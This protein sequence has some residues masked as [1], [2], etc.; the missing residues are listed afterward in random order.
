M[1]R[2]LARLWRS[3]GA[4]ALAAL[5]AAAGCT[6]EQSTPQGYFPEIPVP[7]Q[8]TLDGDQTAPGFD[9]DGLFLAFQSS[10]PPAGVRTAY[11]AQLRSAGFLPGPDREGWRAY[12]RADQVLWVSVADV[13]PPTLL[14]VRVAS[15][16]D[17]ASPSTLRSAAPG[18][19][20][21]AGPDGPGNTQGAT[22]PLPLPA[23]PTVT[24][25]PATPEPAVRR[26][27][28]PFWVPPGQGGSNPGG[29]PGN[30]HGGNGDGGGNGNGNGAGQ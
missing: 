26:G 28:N 20:H 30:P 5:T 11:D 29:E 18:S 8:A 23:S 22:G 17:S 7:R 15:P 1:I 10:L 14:V 4:I 3:G 12:Q 13:G 21:P 6:P 27:G 25:G 16:G 9:A 2:S 24:A 19:D